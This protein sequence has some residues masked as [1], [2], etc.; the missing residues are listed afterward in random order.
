[1]IV[2]PTFARCLDLL[3]CCFDEKQ[4]L[5]K[6][7]GVNF[8]R[9]AE[10]SVIE[11][12]L[13]IADPILGNGLHFGVCNGKDNSI[14]K[15]DRSIGVFSKNYLEISIDQIY[16][17][18]KKLEGLASDALSDWFSITITKLDGSLTSGQRNYVPSAEKNKI[19]IDLT[20]ELEQFK[21]WED[22]VG[23]Y[24]Y[25]LESGNIYAYS[26]D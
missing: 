19:F 18:I 20:V 23:S 9:I 24:E 10:S 14:I 1:M 2:S 3:G 7:F 15:I 6:L 8:K 4:K 13:L 22:M 26:R 11:Y 5:G 17:A 25:I 12:A 21:D 16:M